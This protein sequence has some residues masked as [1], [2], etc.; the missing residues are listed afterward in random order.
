MKCDTCVHFKHHY[1][2]SFH[3]VSEGW[4]DPYD[5]DCCAKLHWIDGEEPELG[6]E[7]PWLKCKDY[8]RSPN[9]DA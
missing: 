9:E 7:D 8:R 4:D 6:S 2:G 1:S 5:Y 3:E